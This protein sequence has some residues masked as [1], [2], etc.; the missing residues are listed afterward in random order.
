VKDLIKKLET[1]KYSGKLRGA[2]CLLRSKLRNWARWI[3]AYNL[4]M[5][6]FKIWGCVIEIDDEELS[7]FHL[8]DFSMKLLL[9][10][11]LEFISS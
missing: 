3:S 8:E 10:A 4:V 9:R 6:Y 5:R 7:S 2:K 1:L 11:C